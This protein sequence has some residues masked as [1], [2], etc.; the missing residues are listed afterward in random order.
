M[1]T[2]G[3]SIL[4]RTSHRTHSVLVLAWV[5]RSQPKSGVRSYRHPGS[6]TPRNRWRTGT[7]LYLRRLRQDNVVTPLV[8]SGLKVSSHPY[9]KMGTGNLQLPAAKLH[10][11]GRSPLAILPLRAPEL[12]CH[13]LLILSTFKYTAHK[14]NDMGCGLIPVRIQAERM[15]LR[16]GK[17][18]KV[19]V[20]PMFRLRTVHFH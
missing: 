18:S 5:F 15:L 9:R 20:A 13:H 10:G 19:V 12:A 3:G 11:C 7:R 17:L 6:R 14:P 8:S 4:G 1:I 2:H 16:L